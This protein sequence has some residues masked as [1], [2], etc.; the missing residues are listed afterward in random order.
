MSMLVSFT[1]AALTLS[2]MITI[3]VLIAV[4]VVQGL[5]S[6]FDMPTRQA[7]VVSLIEDKRDLGNAIALN[8][9]MFNAARLVGPSIAGALIA[10]SNEGWCFLIDGVSF[11]AVIAA[12]L[13]MRVPPFAAPHH[14]HASAI[15]QFTEGWKYAFES[16]AIR[17]IIMLIAL[18]CL[19]GVPYSVLMPI[20]AANILGGGANTLGFLMTASGG[21][22]LLGAL[23]LA[24]RRTVHG[25][26][27]VI[28]ISASIFGLAL[29]AFAASRMLWLSLILL[30]VA[31]FGL[32]VQIAS[33]NTLLQTIVE[34]SKRGRVIA[35]FLMAFFGTTPIG[36]LVAGWLS[37]RFGAPIVIA[38]GGACCVVGAWV[39]REGLASVHEALTTTFVDAALIANAG[40]TASTM[41]AV[42]STSASNSAA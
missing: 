30:V 26:T 22:A 31:G 17:S 20:F 5:V 18:V 3:E 24:T 41:A 16:T 25:L 35:F 8:S 1:L 28:P 7:F 33:S 19:V 2:G 4:S 27:R 6:A 10:M 12:L 9:S 32:M 29:I 37:D 11:L 15:K 38:C 14:A 42:P 39:L 36:S 40:V 34:D 23:W 13:A 21:G